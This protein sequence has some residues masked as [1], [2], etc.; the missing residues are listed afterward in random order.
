LKNIEHVLLHSQANIFL[1]DL[2]GMPAFI[3]MHPEVVEAFFDSQ[4]QMLDVSAK[5]KENS[6]EFCYNF[7]DTLKKK[8]EKG[9]EPAI[10]IE[11]GVFI[12]LENCELKTVNKEKNGRSRPI[13]NACKFSTTRTSCSEPNR[14]KFP[15]SK[16]E[17]TVLAVLA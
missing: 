7:L 10:K 3:D 2:R 13:E 8:N 4:I 11:N 12:L 9:K 14:N 17:E 16:M 5:N 6:I 1:P 15:A